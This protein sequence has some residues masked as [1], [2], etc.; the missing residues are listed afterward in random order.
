MESASHFGPWDQFAENERRFGLKTDYDETMYTTAIDRS[1]PQYKQRLAEAD[2]KAKEIQNTAALTAHVAEE[3]VMDHA[4]NH[5]KSVDEEEK[6]SGVRRQQDFPPLSTGGPNTYTPPARRAPTSKSGT[7]GA[8]VDPAIISSAIKGQVNKSSAS[9]SQEAKSQIPVA[10]PQT[11]SPPVPDPKLEATTP[12]DSKLG[13]KSEARPI[14]AKAAETPKVT[15]KTAIPLR[16]A[17]GTTATTKKE[18]ITPSATS[19]VERDVLNSFK[20]FAANQRMKAAQDRH[21]KAKQDKEIKLIE[22]KKF[23]DSFKLSTP[24]PNDLICII[25]KDPLKQ[26]QIQQKALQNAEEMAKAKR[27]AVKEK[28]ASAAKDT[29]A[30]KPT[31]TE[32]TTPTS[33]SESRAGPS[34]RHLPAP[35]AAAATS[36][37]VRHSNNRQPYGQGYHNPNNFRNNQS[38]GHNM[39]SAPRTGNLAPRLRNIEA[40]KLNM[41]SQMNAQGS[42]HPHIS[43]QDMRP[44][45]TGP[46]SSMDFGNSARRLS[47][48]PGG[49]GGK[50][51]P[52][53]H[54]FRPT[55]VPAFVPQFHP[56]SGHPSAGSSPRSSV[57]HLVDPSSA[58]SN[59]PTANR[60]QLVRKKTQVDGSKFKILSFVKTAK[61][62]PTKNWD[63]NDGMRPSYDTL[64]TWRQVQDEE[65]ADSTMH[66]TYPQYFEKQ[67]FA[68][69]SSMATPNPHHS[70]PLAHQHQLPFHLQQHSS[71]MAPRQ[72][73]HMAH[74]QIHTGHPPPPA[75]FNNGDDHRMMPSGSSQSFQS[76]R[77]APIPMAYPP[78]IPA[79]AQQV[80]YPAQPGMPY[81][82]GAGGPIP[83][84]YRNFNPN[85]PYIPPQPHM[86]QPMIMQQP[87]PPQ[88]QMY[89]G[90]HQ[91]Q[92]IPAAGGPVQPM[93]GSNGYPSP[94]R[95]QAPMMAPQGSQ[96]GQP[97]MYGMSPG[98]QYQ[99]PANFP[100]QQPGQG[101]FQKNAPPAHMRKY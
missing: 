84:Q 94:G 4:G 87:F 11:K 39:N 89:P 7:P 72:S 65:P 38:P 85:Q 92:F 23:A 8:P 31:A 34:T 71:H 9:K 74:M 86:G 73:P 16:P 49:M 30:A 12:A 32:Q 100:P 3:R 19:T 10:L 25:A 2:K 96:Q 60:G 95:P 50:L 69:P 24:V 78:S 5:D 61:P 59:P 77:I 68:G 35:A 21:N 98:M 91:P 52:N 63:D 20:S 79:A 22:L 93:P 97:S 14:D 48:A 101:K 90:G 66:L 27:D 62:P 83:T 36:T 55:G 44:P 28:E 37:P 13:S 46:A 47:G 56:N 82:P 41:S 75:Q 1:H 51:N 17:V 15:E 26:Q 53:S 70:L 80:P 54:E 88:M 18:G 33:Q 45:P 64:P 67:P 43:V 99:Q 57:N 42:H 6:Y 76:P 29:Q 81:M 40:N 58:G